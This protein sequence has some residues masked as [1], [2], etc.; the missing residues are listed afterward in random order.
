[1]ILERHPEV[2]ALTA[3]EKLQLIRELYDAL[4]V[5]G[6]LE[7]NPSIVAELH[8]RREE[9]LRDPSQVVPWQEVKRKLAEGAWW[10]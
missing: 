1:M 8:Q 7:P 5:T 10:K 3:D 4:E 9:Y 6:E 2:A